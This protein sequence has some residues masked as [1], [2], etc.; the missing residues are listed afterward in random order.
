MRFDWAVSSA[1][2]ISFLETLTTPHIGR[3]TRGFV[4]LTFH[5]LLSVLYFALEVQDGE[6]YYDVFYISTGCGFQ[7]G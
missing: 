5:H 7:P 1:C 2:L 4:P 3:V 6:Y